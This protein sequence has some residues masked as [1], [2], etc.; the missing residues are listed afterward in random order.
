MFYHFNCHSGQQILSMFYFNY[1][2]EGLKYV[3]SFQLSFWTAIHSVACDMLSTERAC[4]RPQ[5]KLEDKV[6]WK[7]SV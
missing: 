5:C 4:T 6:K 7:A 3:L 2:I 1:V